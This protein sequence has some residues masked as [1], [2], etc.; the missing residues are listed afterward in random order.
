[1][2][3][4]LEG[5]PGVKT[6]C[7]YLHF[8]RQ[9]LTKGKMAYS[10]EGECTSQQFAG[11]PFG[12]MEGRIAFGDQMVIQRYYATIRGKYALSFIQTF[13]SDEGEARTRDILDSVRLDPVAEGK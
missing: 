12:Y 3:E 5:F 7:D 6:G 11:A 1:V 9:L 10:F 2:A 13:F 4:N 8:V